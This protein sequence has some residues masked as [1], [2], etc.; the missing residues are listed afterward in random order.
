MLED[1]LNTRVK[2]RIAVLFSKEKGLL[3]VSDVA[4][5]LAISRSRASECLKDL[6][7]CGLLKSRT[8]GRS[9]V[10]EL[11]PTKLA[12]VIV[13]AL[14]MDEKLLKEIENR[15]KKELAKLKPVS[16][17]RFGSSVTA[18]KPESDIDIIVLLKENT[19][20]DEIYSISAKLSEEF[21]IHISILA[22]NVEEFKKKARKGEE[23][24][25][26]VVATHTLIHGKN[27][28]GIIWQKK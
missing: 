8:I 9:I 23:F 28:E 25:L 3:Q 22:M 26:K 17:A 27:L 20:K 24:A 21:G 18:M 15:L 1:I 13:R 12:G 2:T 5:K 7:K 16:I 11:S 19:S 10:Y 6:E 14:R 4:R